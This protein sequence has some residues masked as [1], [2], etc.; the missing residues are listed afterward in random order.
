M[1]KEPV[2]ADAAPKKGGGVMRLIKMLL[3]SAVLVGAGFGGGLTGQSMSGAAAILS[4]VPEGD[5]GL[6]RDDAGRFFLFSTA[7]LSGDFQ[8]Y[9]YADVTDLQRI[10][11]ERDDILQFLSHDIRSPNAAIVTLLETDALAHIAE[12]SGLVWVHSDGDKVQQVQAAIAAEPK[13]IHVPREIKPAV[14]LD[15]GPLVLVETRKDLRSMP[16]PFETQ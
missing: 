5:N 13:P 8:I 16:L 6:L 7:E 9:S 2:T 15:E 3:G 11:E 1:A 12:A 10:A 4:P 14:V